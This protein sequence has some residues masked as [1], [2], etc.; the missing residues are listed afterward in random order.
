MN[1]LA[2]YCNTL[3]Q[4]EGISLY[5]FCN[6][7]NLERTSI[8]R[9]LNGERLPKEEHFEAFVHALSITSAEADTLRQFYQREKIGPVS[10]DNRIFIKKLL[11]EIGEEHHF[12]FIRE[13]HSQH[14]DL[15]LKDMAAA[16]DIHNF[17]EIQYLIHILFT[18][19][20]Y[21]IY[22]NI[23]VD[24]PQLF[25]VL[26]QA[27]Y[28]KNTSVPFF[29]LFTM[30]KKS[31]LQH[32]S[33]YNLN[34]FTSVIPLS[35]QINSVYYPLY[36][37]GYPVAEN[38]CT[39]F[40]YYVLTSDYLLLIDLEGKEAILSSDPALIRAYQKQCEKIQ[41]R[42]KHLIMH[43][44]DLIQSLKMHSSAANMDPSVTLAYTFD[45]FPCL[46][47]I[48][49]RELF[50]P[51]IKPAYRENSALMQI[52]DE[53]SNNIKQFTVYEAI[54]VYEGLINFAK[55]GILADS[56]DFILDPFHK[57]E[58]R[59]ILEKLKNACI[60]GSYHLHILPKN[61]FLN[62]PQI[63]IELYNNHQISLISLNQQHLFSRINLSENSIYDSFV[64]YF[65]GLS[66]QPDVTSAKNSAKIIQD[67][68]VKYL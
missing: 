16:T 18:T 43:S 6:T 25:K 48:Y 57:E 12:H 52:V 17:K 42:S 41:A 10:Y 14:F 27:F 54:V 62:T 5:R 60:D 37:Y 61:Y 32:N 30:L 38:D 22:S 63:N 33:N 36:A 8:R 15:Q 47:Q 34:I 31:S 58:R 7:H 68:I 19:A 53:T 67:I 11:E 20:K 26:Q 44:N 55:T 46:F 13:P 45:F 59:T 64:D 51:H 1:Q 35:F 40:P 23:S 65:E 50:A 9:L 49:S 28:D 66:K 3:F 21:F 4:A 39:P 56:L 29:H 2:S 24:H